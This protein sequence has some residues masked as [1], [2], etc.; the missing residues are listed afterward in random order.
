MSFIEKT[1]ENH[2]FQRKAMAGIDLAR[3]EF[4][5]CC[6]KGCDLSESRLT[7]AVFIDC[8]FIDC[9]LS[10]IKTEGAGF[11]QVVFEGCK[12]VGVQFRAVSPFL[13]KWSFMQCK[14]ELCD[15]SSIKMKRSRFI[16]CRFR[17]TDFVD[18]DLT[19]SDFSRSDLTNCQFHH[20][21]LES[22]DFSQAIN[23]EIDPMINRV[24][25]AIFSYPEAL[26][27]LSPFKIKII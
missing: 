12:L 5:S 25:Q 7:A 27:L 4:S 1:Y 14:I 18:A 13:L 20:T 8:T 22:A 9:N 24:K 10:N 11:R 6:F 26:A 3:K 23:Y 16:D 15:F 17:G 19:G 21:N 2:T